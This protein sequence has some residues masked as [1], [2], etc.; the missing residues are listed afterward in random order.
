MERGESWTFPHTS[1]MHRRCT[2][3]RRCILVRSRVK[4]T[5]GLFVLIIISGHTQPILLTPRN[6]NILLSLLQP[7]PPRSR[8]NRT[9]Q[10]KEAGGMRP[11]ASQQLQQPQHTRVKTT[12]KTQHRAPRHL[13]KSLSSSQ[14]EL[15]EKARVV[16]GADRTGLQDGPP[17][18]DTDKGGGGGLDSPRDSPRTR[19]R[20]EQAKILDKEAVASQGGGGG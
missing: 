3:H 6:P 13:R 2:V 8:V 10:R 16:A 4:Y 15:R 20:L 12:R 1:H 19:Q 18:T 7:S 9:R 5:T 11:P 17:M 14:P